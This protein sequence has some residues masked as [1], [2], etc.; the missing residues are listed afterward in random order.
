MVDVYS[1]YTWQMAAK[2]D[3]ARNAVEF[4]ERVLG[5]IEERWDRAGVTTLAEI[6]TD[7]G[8][9]FSHDQ[10]VVP[11]QQ[12]LQHWQITF[13]KANSNTPNQ[14]A[15]IEN[16]N[17]EWRNIA[18][19]VLEVKSGNLTEAQL[20]AK[21]AG[22]RWHGGPA[23][24]ALGVQLREIN[25]LMNKRPNTTRGNESPSRIL[26]AALEPGQ[27]F[28]ESGQPRTEEQDKELM[29][30]VNATLLK[31]QA[32]RRGASTIKPYEEGDLVRLINA[33][34]LKAST[35]SNA[36]KMGPRWS[37]TVYQITKVRGRTGVPEYRVEPV[38]DLYKGDFD[39]R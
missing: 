1:G 28:D 2:N 12:S 38:E 4:V 21:P 23:N 11:L 27:G 37:R 25:A 29:K 6:K 22:A 32:S 16:A 14:M 30:R 20:K 35:R 7:N 19:R 3:T 18:R 39:N 26:E 8:A 5:S 33:K 13:R 15:F 34:Y 9:S 10:F 36:L 24:Q 31:S 17:R